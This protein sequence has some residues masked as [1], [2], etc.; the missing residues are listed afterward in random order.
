[1][2]DLKKLPRTREE[3]KKIGINHYFKN[4][5]CRNGHLQKRRV[6]DGH[7]LDCDSAYQKRKRQ[8]RPEHVSKTR[9]IYYLKTKDHQLSLRRKRYAESRAFRLR[10]KDRD[11]QKAYGITLD[12]YKVMQEQQKHLCAICFLKDSNKR[13]KGLCVDH[14]HDTKQVRGLLCTNCNQ[15]LG[16]FFDNEELLRNAIAY[17]EQYKEN[18]NEKLRSRNS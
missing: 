7:C 12:D 13:T 11:L 3:A 14:C 9:K 4:E 8:N 15:G 2:D 16:K 18:N 6:S 17:L 5:P 10:K 1:M